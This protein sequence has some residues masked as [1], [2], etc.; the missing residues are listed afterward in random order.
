MRK[1]STRA[2]SEHR[3]EPYAVGQP[4]SALFTAARISSMVMF[5]SWFVSPGLQAETLML[6]REMLTIVRIS[7]IVTVPVPL[8]S[9]THVP[10][11]TV[12]VGVSVA[13]AEGGGVGVTV[14]VLVGVLGGVFVTVAVVV[15]VPVVVGV[16]VGVAVGMV[17][18]GVPHGA[19]GVA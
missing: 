19:V 4:V 15:G 3:H 10:E 5:P 1:R 17:G 2:R 18:V 14:C 13:V 8:Q 11:D 12:F 16:S 7:S 9:P 6:A